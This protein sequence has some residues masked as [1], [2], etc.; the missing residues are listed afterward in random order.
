MVFGRQDAQLP[1]R[2]PLNQLSKLGN[3]QPCISHLS[4]LR[5]R[6]S[7]TNY[8]GVDGGEFR[9]C[10]VEGENFGCKRQVRSAGQVPRSPF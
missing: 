10:L 3:K 2:L 8:G 4:R 7:F 6:S 9:E 5:A 1:R